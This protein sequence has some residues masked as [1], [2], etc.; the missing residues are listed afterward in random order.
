[1]LIGCGLRRAELVG[2]R[3]DDL[4]IREEHWVI[5]DPTRMLPASD[6]DG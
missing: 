4:Q 1:L 3:S 2:L 6:R 5:A